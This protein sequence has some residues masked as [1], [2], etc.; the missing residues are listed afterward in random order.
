MGKKKAVILARV[1]TE[2]QAENGYS[3]I[4]QLAACQKYA[5]DKGWDIIE[6]FSDDCSGSIPVAD[7]PGG[8][9]VYELLRRE[10]VDY[11]IMYTLDRS[12]RDKR[13]YPIEY[14]IFLRDIQDAG[15]ELHFTDSGRSEGGIVDLFRAWQASEERRKIKERSM[16][17]KRAKAAAG[18]YVGGSQIPF[19]YKWVGK[20]RTGKLVV[21]GETSLLVKEIFAWYVVERM[22]LKGIADKLNATGIRSPKADLR[23][24]SSTGKWCHSTIRK[25]IMSRGYI[26]EF[27]YDGIT[28]SLPELAIIEQDMFEI[29]QSNL[30]RNKELSQRNRKLDYLLTGYFRCV[31]GATM[32]G[33]HGNFRQ[34]GTARRYYRCASKQYAFRIDCSQKG[35]VGAPEVENL[36]WVHIAEL[37]TH[38]EKLD[39]GIEEMRQNHEEIVA[40]K[41]ARLTVVQESIKNVEARMQRLVTELG[42]I[43]EEVIKEMIKKELT[44]LSKERNA[45]LSEVTELQQEIS[46]QIITAEQRD[47]ILQIAADIGK[48]IENATYEQKRRLFELMGLRVEWLPITEGKRFKITCKIGPEIILAFDDSSY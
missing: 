1:S 47:E 35:I 16:R 37:L 30:K 34:D 7:R 42:T 41:K 33:G 13:E 45:W 36:V 25:M 32:G 15:A 48:R 22:T 39:E 17:G 10:A 4:T 8:S 18:K 43:E 40:P 3:L 46:K 31:C 23:K 2:Q 20:G 5:T 19:G 9:Q 12:A 28:I 11:V 14:L 21:D 6:E 29:A 44:Q 26:G 27:K 38:P 24:R